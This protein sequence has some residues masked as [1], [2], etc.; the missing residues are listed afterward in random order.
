MT[1]TTTIR[2]DV[3]VKKK[4]LVLEQDQRH[5][6]K[7]YVRF[8]LDTTV[9]CNCYVMFA[10]TETVDEAG[11]VVFSYAN[12]EEAGPVAFEAGL[13]QEYLSPKRNRLDVSKLTSEQLVHVPNSQRFPLV[14]KLEATPDGVV[15]TGSAVQCQYT[16]AT[17]VKN[18]HDKF[19]A[20]V[21][22]Q[23]IQVGEVC[24][25]LQEIY[26]IEQNDSGGGDQDG[27]GDCVICMTEP[28]DT[29]VLPCRHMCLCGECAKRLRVQTNKCPI[30]R[31]PVESLLQI[32]VSREEEEQPQQE[33]QQPQEKPDKKGKKSKS[34]KK[35]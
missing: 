13:G 20:Q 8:A 28:K 17:L 1:Q 26:G 27:Q 16:Y 33:D 11:N 15:P 23:K 14:V 19:E 29:T 9:R 24:Y 30:C 34:S 12:A 31:H 7:Y 18:S 2:N 3:N 22:K 32:T 4:S 21:V 35:E 5:P 6:D 25:E 10:A